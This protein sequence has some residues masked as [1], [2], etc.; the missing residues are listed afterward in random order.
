MPVYFIITSVNLSFR[1]ETKEQHWAAQTQTGPRRCRLNPSGL[2]SSLI[3][4]HWFRLLSRVCWTAPT[5]L[6]HVSLVSGNTKNT[7]LVLLTLFKF[8]ASKSQLL[9]LTSRLVAT[10]CLALQAS[11]TL[12]RAAALHRPL[13]RGLDTPVLAP[14]PTTTRSC[15]AYT[16]SLVVKNA[17][18]RNRILMSDKVLAN[19]EASTGKSPSS[20]A[21]EFMGWGVACAHQQR[22]QLSGGGAGVRFQANSLSWGTCNCVKSGFLVLVQGCC[23]PAQS[24]QQFHTKTQRW[25]SLLQI[26]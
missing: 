20:T 2:G 14:L 8:P 19:M 10:A 13:W 23:H 25:I 9:W 16:L 17:S 22:E 3:R 7:L 11:T 26:L 12:E 18:I 6:K 24:S 4:T 15:Q 5:R 1:R 21:E